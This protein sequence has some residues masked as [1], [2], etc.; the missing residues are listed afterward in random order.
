MITPTLTIKDT[1]LDQANPT[2]EETLLT[3]TLSGF[4]IPGLLGGIAESFLKSRG[5]IEVASTFKVEADQTS[6]D[7]EITTYT[8]TET[9]SSKSSLVQTLLKNYSTKQTITELEYE[10]LLDVFPDLKTGS[11]DLDAELSFA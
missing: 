11:F 3:K 4:S 1:G 9:V 7:G 6:T 5:S 10:V 8:L 2:T